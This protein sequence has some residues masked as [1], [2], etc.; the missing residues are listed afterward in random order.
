MT[1]GYPQNGVTPTETQQQSPMYQPPVAPTYQPPTNPVY[2]P[3]ASPASQQTNYPPQPG[4]AP[5]TPAYQP[6]YQ[7]AY[8]EYPPTQPQYAQPFIQPGYPQR[9]TPKW[10]G[11]A[12]AGF[13]LSFLFPIAGLPLSI[14]AFIQTK[15]SGEKGHGLALAGIIISAVIT[16]IALTA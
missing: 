8:A 7:P 4:Y 2:L 3:P 12:I 10:N 9:T 1:D 6:A 15:D 5:P 11:L 16:A 13:V 14:I